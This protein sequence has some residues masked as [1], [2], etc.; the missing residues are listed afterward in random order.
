MR[1][2]NRPSGSQHWTRQHPEYRTPWTKLKVTRETL[3]GVRTRQTARVVWYNR[4]YET[5][6]LCNQHMGIAPERMVLMPPHNTTQPVA[7]RFWRH[8]EKSDGCWEWIG[9]LDNDGYGRI[10]DGRRNRKAHRVAYELTY[11]PIPSGLIIRH[12]CDNPA[13]VRPDHLLS[14]THL[15]NAQDK[16]ERGR[17][18]SG[19]DHWTRRAPD[20][21]Q[22]W[23]KLRPDQ[24]AE[25]CMLYK[26]GSSPDWLARR[27]GVGRVTVWRYARAHGLVTPRRKHLKQFSVT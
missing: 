15:D 10:R 8:V 2:S 21:R 25:L 27:F 24:I 9:A 17:A 6:V 12:T 19:D 4:V 11:G 7:D 1:H 3:F 5:H 23:A 26:G 18:P 22:S 13:C 14:G 16:C 20:M